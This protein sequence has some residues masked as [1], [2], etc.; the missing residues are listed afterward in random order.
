[1]G[2]MQITWWVAH[3]INSGSQKYVS[4]QARISLEINFD[5]LYV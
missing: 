1:M 5:Q 4:I 3:L 2:E